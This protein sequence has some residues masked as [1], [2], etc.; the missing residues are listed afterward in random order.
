MYT[1]YVCGKLKADNLR[2]HALSSS[3]LLLPPPTHPQHTTSKM[4]PQM[5]QAATQ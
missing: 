5:F 4:Q 3:L 2:A 1:I